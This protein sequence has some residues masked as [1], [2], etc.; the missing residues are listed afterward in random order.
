MSKNLSPELSQQFPY[1]E[2]AYFCAGIS[3]TCNLKE[4]TIHGEDNSCNQL[5][6]HSISSRSTESGWEAYQFHPHN[7]LSSCND[8]PVFRKVEQQTQP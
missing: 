6:G 3:A 4:T 1:L 8:C 7:P 2:I 5:N